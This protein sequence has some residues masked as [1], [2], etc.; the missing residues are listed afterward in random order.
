[1]STAPLRKA[2][3]F[4]LVELVLVLSIMGILMSVAAPT[5]RQS[6]SLQVQGSARLLTAHLEMARTH[7]L[8]QRM[9]T[10]VVFYESTR[11]YTAYTDHDRNGA[12]AQTEIERNA[13]QAFGRRELEGIVSFGR[14]NASEFPGDPAS[15]PVTITA[16]ELDLDTQ[17]LPVPWGTMGTVYL[18]HR[19]N[20]NAVSA[21]SISSSGSFKA[22]RWHPDEEEW[23]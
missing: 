20:P 17:G 18:V 5:F 8:G 3:G 1:M 4:T 12:I 22:W 11:S 7:A 15:G 14:G 21:V 10:Q 13:F 9:N 2:A 16:N 23:R 6:P 19:D